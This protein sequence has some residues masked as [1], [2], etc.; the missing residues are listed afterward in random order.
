M[1]DGVG[2]FA[3]W[4]AIGAINIAFWAAI[5]PLIKALA[6]RVRGGALPAGLEARIEALEAGRPIT[7]ETDAVYHRLAEMEERLDFTERLLAQGR[8]AG[9]IEEGQ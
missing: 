5:S 1:G 3:F 7:G 4:I 9:R 6:D 8:E 2:D